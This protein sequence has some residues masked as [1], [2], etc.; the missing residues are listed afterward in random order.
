MRLGF[1]SHLEAKIQIV[2]RVLARVKFDNE[3]SVDL[4]QNCHVCLSGKL[5]MSTL[6]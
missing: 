3:Q 2:P 4:F 1:G 5:Q 6:K